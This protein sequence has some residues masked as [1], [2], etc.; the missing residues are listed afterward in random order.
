MKI[1]RWYN[2]HDIRIEEVPTPV[3]G[4][5][6]MLV[7]VISCGICGSDIVEW[8]RLPRAPLVPGHEIGAEVA[9]VGASVADYKP[10]DRVF[11]APKVP[12]MQCTYCKSG[13]YPVCAN[14]GQRLPGGMAEYILVPRVLVERGTYRLPDA[15]SYD[16]S[17]F[18]EPLACAVRSQRLAGVC[19][20]QTVVVVG[21]GMSGLLQVKLAVARGCRVIATD[22]N[23]KRLTAAAGMGAKVVIDAAEDVAERIAAE[24]GRKADVVILCTSAMAAVEQAWNCVDKGGVVVFFAVPAPGKVVTIPINDF[25][26]REIDVRTSYYCGPP[27]IKE[28]ISLLAAGTIRVDDMITHRLALNDVARGFQLVLDGTESMKVIIKPQA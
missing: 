1:V 17:T 3:P 5:D 9:Q 6:E 13:H 8:Y 16:Q 24:T 27:D 4:S 20:G 7:K 15:I 28:A 21:C 12:C 2:N 22:V 10:G 11:I 23:R 25:W 14:V 26:T 19:S 18:I